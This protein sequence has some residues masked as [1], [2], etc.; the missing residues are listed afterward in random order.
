ME[1]FGNEFTTLFYLIDAANSGKSMISILSEDTDVF[2]L[3]VCWC[4]G[5]RWMQGADGTVGYDVT[6]LGHS[7]CSSMACT[8]SETATYLIS[9]HRI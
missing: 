5:R 4:I 1:H 3:L 2:V 8:P 6:T 7:V 9:I